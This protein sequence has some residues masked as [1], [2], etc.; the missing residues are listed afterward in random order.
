MRKFI[1][2]S[3]NYERLAEGAKGECISIEI[4]P[5]HH[6][7]AVL[8]ALPYPSQAFYVVSGGEVLQVL[9]DE[10]HLIEWCEEN[11]V[12]WDTVYHTEE[13]DQEITRRVEE[14]K[15]SK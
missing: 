14:E 4:K 1:R 15:P 10:N 2:R 8:T 5:G 12:V 11:K 6:R 9:H 3:K 7:G 13:S